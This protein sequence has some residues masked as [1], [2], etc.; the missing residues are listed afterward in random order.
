[1]RYEATRFGVRGD[2]VTDG[3]CHIVADYESADFVDWHGDWFNGHLFPA[4]NV[5]SPQWGGDF[6]LRKEVR[7]IYPDLWRTVHFQYLHG[8]LSWQFN[9][10]LNL[11]R[12]RS[13]R[14][15]Q[16]ALKTGPNE[17]RVT[18]SHIIGA[19]RFHDPDE[20]NRTL[21]SHPVV[22]NAEE[23]VF[24]A[25]DLVF[26]QE[27]AFILAKRR[28]MPGRVKTVLPER[29]QLI[30]ETERP[31]WTVKPEVRSRAYP[32]VL[33]PAGTDSTSIE[34][35]AGAPSPT[36]LRLRNGRPY[37]NWGYPEPLLRLFCRDNGHARL[38]RAQRPSRIRRRRVDG[39][40]VALRVAVGQ[41]L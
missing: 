26:L 29:N 36:Y 39:E 22:A 18:L 19:N 7:D 5:P 17:Y 35:A 30:V 41:R 12:D 13:T 40:T 11:F 8:N 1:V 20:P 37:T 3:P 21:A 33:G 9:N 32:A 6:L 23:S 38:D 24:R 27:P 16:E 25:G 4:N 15:V 34:L 2:I 28:P 10:Y 31:L 14:A